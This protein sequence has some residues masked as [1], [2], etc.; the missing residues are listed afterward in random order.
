MVLEPSTKPPIDIELEK[1]IR[2]TA[3]LMESGT[4]LMF[5]GAFVFLVCVIGSI[6]STSGA[7]DLLTM[8]IL[9]SLFGFLGFN[10]AR[11]AGDK[12]DVL[13]ANR[14]VAAS[15]SIENVEVL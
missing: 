8:G 14:T 5:S 12:Y 1:K 10:K 11:K 2:E 13:I 7:A 15:G 3:M 6:A 4:R 9:G